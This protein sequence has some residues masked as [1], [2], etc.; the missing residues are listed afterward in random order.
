MREGA[1]SDVKSVFAPNVDRHLATGISP[2]K[3]ICSHPRGDADASEGAGHCSTARIKPVQSWAIAWDNSTG[4]AG[5]YSVSDNAPQS[6]P[7]GETDGC[8][9][10]SDAAAG[11]FPLIE[12]AGVH[13]AEHLQNFWKSMK[14]NRF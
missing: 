3:L 1:N 2:V 8:E 7:G 9:R 12:V 10:V 13:A 14:P 4:F 11:H 6:S 5:R